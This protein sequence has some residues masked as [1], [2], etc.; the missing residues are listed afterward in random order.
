MID[1]EGHIKIA[2]FGLSKEGMFEKKMTNT[3]LG[4][5]RS[6]M[7]PE[8]IME[9][10]YEKSVDLYLFGLLAYELMAGKAAYPPDIHD[11]ED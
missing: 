7:I 8:V 2:D 10:S 11:L 6:Y 4:G 9:K 1:K 5:G 3:I